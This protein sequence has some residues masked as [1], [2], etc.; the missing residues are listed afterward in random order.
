MLIAAVCINILQM[1]LKLSLCS[2]PDGMIMALPTYTLP[3]LFSS[4]Y[5]FKFKKTIYEVSMCISSFRIY[6]C[7]LFK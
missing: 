1:V 4:I 6:V 7:C 2:H 5:I 3:F